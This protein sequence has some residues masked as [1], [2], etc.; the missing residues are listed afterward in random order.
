MSGR[1]LLNGTKVVNLIAACTPG[2]WDRAIT[3]SASVGLDAITLALCRSLGRG[4]W[5]PR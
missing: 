3:Q 4:G 5:L 2:Y 1:T